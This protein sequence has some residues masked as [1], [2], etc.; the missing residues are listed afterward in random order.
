MSNFYEYEELV[1]Q[2]WSIHVED[3]YQQP[4]VATPSGFEQT[5]EFRPPNPDE[6]FINCGDGEA[7]QASG[8]HYCDSRSPRLILRKKAK[9]RVLVAE[10]EIVPGGE[11]I[12]YKRSE[13]TAK[14]LVDNRPSVYRIEERD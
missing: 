8:S 9:R 6:W 2:K 5:G 1:K 13:L 3:I 4:N 7:Q 11:G 12:M 10:Y 14:S